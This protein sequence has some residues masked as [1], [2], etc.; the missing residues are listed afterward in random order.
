MSG[1]FFVNKYILFIDCRPIEPL[2]VSLLIK[3][4]LHKQ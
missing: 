2:F 1:L 4:L 3:V